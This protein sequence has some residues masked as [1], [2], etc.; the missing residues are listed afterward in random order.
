MLT[1]GNIILGP[2]PKSP[3]CGFTNSYN[4][5]GMYTLSSYHPGGCNVVMGDGS[6]RFLKDSIALPTVWAL[7]SRCA[8]RGDLGRLVL[9]PGVRDGTTSHSRGPTHAH[10]DP[11]RRRRRCG[12]APADARE[13][14]HRRLRR[15]RPRL[16]RPRLLRPP[17]DQ[18]ARARPAGDARGSA[19]PPSTPAPR[20]ARPRG[21]PCSP[22]GT[23]TGSA[24]AT[25]SSRTRAST[26][27]A[28]R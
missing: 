4:S 26:C 23:R 12:L 15:R 1:L 24:S 11:A 7:G 25:G 18:D 2:N 16:R 19:S 22:A 10:C 8:G 20:S 13:A 5:G 3:N 28:P 17:A 6:V 27:P 14:Q 21:P 9:T